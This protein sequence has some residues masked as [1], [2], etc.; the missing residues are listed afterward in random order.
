MDKKKVRF[1]SLFY[2]DKHIVYLTLN[3]IL[4]W[5]GCEVKIG[6]IYILLYEYLLIDLIV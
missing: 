2:D 4:R 1:F 6:N 5:D 3:L